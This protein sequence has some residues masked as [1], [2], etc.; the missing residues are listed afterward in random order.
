MPA[1][2]Q[3]LL[4]ELRAAGFEIVYGHRGEPYV[5]VDGLPRPSFTVTPASRLSP[6]QR[7]ALQ[8]HR[9][10]VCY[11]LELEAIEVAR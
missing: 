1:E 3:R 4:A 7:G 11:A 9:R 6:A 8:A 2:G 10:S 5:T